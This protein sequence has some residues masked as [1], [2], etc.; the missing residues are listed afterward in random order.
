MKTIGG[1]FAYFCE[2]GYSYFT[3]SGRS[4]LRTL[5]STLQKSRKTILLPNFICGTVVALT[6]EFFSD[7]R[8]YPVDERLKTDKGVLD[9]FPKDAILFVVNYFGQRND[10]LESVGKDFFV[11]EDNV[12]CPRISLFPKRHAWASFNSFR[13][14]APVSSGSM[15][16]SSIELVDRYENIQPGPAPYEEVRER[17]LALRGPIINGIFDQEEEY[18]QLALLE[19]RLRAEQKEVYSPST[20]AFS[21]ITKFFMT[22][23]DERKA[24]KENYSICKEIIG[25]SGIDLEVEFPTFFLLKCSNRDSIRAELRREK[26]FLP[27]HWRANNEQS[28]RLSDQILS[29]P[30]DGRYTASDISQVSTRIRELLK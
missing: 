13:K 9:H 25:E 24:R 1:D 16:S 3:D 27:I 19:K 22:Y 8:Y 29:V 10:I 12:F 23:D 7:I 26:I 4:S 14:L 5:F 21:E 18:L 20:G 30:V 15:L 11:V 2:D 28:A 6:S 17:I